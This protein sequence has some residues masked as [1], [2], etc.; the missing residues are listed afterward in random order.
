MNLPF[1]GPFKDKYAGR[2]HLMSV[3]RQ[4][5]FFYASPR[6][7]YPFSLMRKHISQVME[8]DLAHELEVKK[9]LKSQVG[10]DSIGFRNGYFIL[11]F[12]EK[13]CFSHE[14]V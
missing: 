4:T 1:E 11:V 14:G 9:I 10:V 5:C 3:L 13:A 6:Y 2:T 12:P 8:F 7:G